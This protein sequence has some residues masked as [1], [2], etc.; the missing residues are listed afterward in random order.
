MIIGKA[1][2]TP[3]N[4]EIFMNAATFSVTSMEDNLLSPPIGLASSSASFWLNAKLAKV[5]T[6][7]D[8]TETSSRLRSSVKCPRNVIF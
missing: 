1:R 7:R 5:V 2:I 6:A 3:L 4:N 8:P